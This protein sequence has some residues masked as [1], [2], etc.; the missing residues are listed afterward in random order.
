MKGLA[1][2]CLCRAHAVPMPFKVPIRRRVLDA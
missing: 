2:T 1:T